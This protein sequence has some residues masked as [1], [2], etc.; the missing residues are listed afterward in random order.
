M[1]IRCLINSRLVIKVFKL[2]I[3]MAVNSDLYEILIKINFFFLLCLI[4]A[5]NIIN[6]VLVT[7]VT[8]CYKKE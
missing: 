8:I 4:I 5:K 3:K 6:I 2:L 1:N 7:I